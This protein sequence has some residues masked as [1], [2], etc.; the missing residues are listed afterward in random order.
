MVY[1]ELELGKLH[2]SSGDCL[3]PAA[4]HTKSSDHAACSVHFS[5]PRGSDGPGRLRSGST[6]RANPV[7]KRAERKDPELVL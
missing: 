2:P 4:G 7:R 1:R 3:I 5:D 6:D